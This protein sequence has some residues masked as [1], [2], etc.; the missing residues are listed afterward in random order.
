MNFK[1][2]KLVLVGTSWQFCWSCLPVSSNWWWVGALK[3]WALNNKCMWIHLGSTNPSTTPPHSLRS[4][5]AAIKYSPTIKA[6]VL[7]IFKFRIW[8]HGR[9]PWNVKRLCRTHRQYYRHPIDVP[10]MRTFKSG[11]YKWILLDTQYFYNI[12]H[13][14]DSKR[15]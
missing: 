8:V 7:C 13:V 10:S 12:C 5:V 2:L 11:G 3:V 9:P 1:T 6:V 4:K 15:K 14:F